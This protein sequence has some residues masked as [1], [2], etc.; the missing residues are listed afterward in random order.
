[1]NGDCGSVT[2][3]LDEPVVAKHPARSYETVAV[4]DGTQGGPR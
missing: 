2:I 1:M 4:Q 3:G